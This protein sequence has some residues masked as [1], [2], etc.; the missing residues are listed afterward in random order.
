MRTRL[1]RDERGVALVLMVLFTALVLGLAALTIDYGMVKTEKA[2]AQR[3]VD[4]AALA[5]ASS[6]IV[7]N[8]AY[9][10]YQG[11]IDTAGKYALLHSVGV[12]PVVS[13]E[14][15][16]VPDLAANTVQVSWARMGI[17]TWFA[18]S[19]GVYTVGLRA[20]ATAH[21]DLS[22][23]ASCVRPVA[24]PDMWNNRPHIVKGKEIEDLNVSKALDYNDKNGNGV[25][26]EGET[27]QWTFDAGLGDAYDQGTT[28]Y[29]TTYR[30]NFGTGNQHK[31]QDYGRQT[32]L[33]SLSS[34]DGA[35]SSF[36]YA[37]GKTKNENSASK[38]AERITSNE[39]ET[40]ELNTNYEALNG[41]NTGPV[42]DA[43][44]ELINRDPSATWNEA[45]NQVTGST[46]GS[47]WLTGSP[48]VIIVGL[49]N[50]SQYGGCP[51]CNRIQLNN[52]AKVF[53][54]RRTCSGH[55]GCKEP[56]T[57]RFLGFVGGGSPTG[58]PPG[59]L[60]KRLVLVR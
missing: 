32:F 6:L 25:W 3:A 36:Y 35:V 8:P 46:A 34:K 7:A 38:L 4:A 15:T 28:G 47:N 26:N 24:I 11:A 12:Q 31:T 40:A 43:W 2:E 44:N 29:G 53:V 37:W 27:E 54:D 10:K 48:R 19:F 39:C 20:T 45:T 51:S 57:G 60:V 59:S 58:S 49:Y 33:M 18:N 56:V 30:D 1:P 5:G 50:P 22:S 41:A 14:V 17:H 42:D 16:I 52:L 55:G 13:G 21:V 9:D 23:T